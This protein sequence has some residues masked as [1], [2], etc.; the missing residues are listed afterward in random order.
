MSDAP[1]KTEMFIVVSMFSLPS[2]RMAAVFS[3]P[4]RIGAGAV[5]LFKKVMLCSLL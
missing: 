2:A 1:Q 4:F 3:K 5:Y